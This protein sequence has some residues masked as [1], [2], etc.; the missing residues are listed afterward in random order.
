MESILLVEDDREIREALK[1]VLEKEGFL[2]ITASNLAEAN[3]EY[4]KKPDLVLL[5]WMLP[6]GQGIEFLRVIRNDRPAL[7]VIFLTARTELVDKVLGLELGADDYITKPFEPREL[8]ARIRARLRRSQST[9]SEASKEKS[10]SEILTQDCISMNL[11]S[12]EVTYEGRP[13]AL[14]RMEMNLLRLFME[15]PGQVFTR[16]E[17]LSRIWGI[18]YPSTRTVDNHILQLRQKFRPDLFET[19]HGV[20]YRFRP[21]KV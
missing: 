9:V 17:L 5:D 20:G 6:D 19:M 4:N 16:D 10:S 18:R 15:H 11:L 1:S 14:T 12:L 7:P 8:I 21:R 3:Q 2:L 13:I